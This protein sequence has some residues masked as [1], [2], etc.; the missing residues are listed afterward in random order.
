LGE[1]PWRFESSRPHLRSSSSSQGLLRVLR[2]GRVRGGRTR[3]PC[4]KPAL[5]LRRPG[6]E[7][8]SPSSA[9]SSPTGAAPVVSMRIRPA[10][11]DG[12][13]CLT[14]PR[15][16]TTRWPHRPGRGSMSSVAPGQSEAPSSFC[17]DAGRGLRRLPAPRAA[18][19][20][21]LVGHRLYVVGGVVAP[22]SLARQM[23]VLDLRTGRWSFV[24]GPQPGLHVS[25]ANEF[26]DLG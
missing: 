18:A 7:T 22:G 25:A 12:G 11:G 8:R 9:A 20:A 4:R 21:A 19:G 17:A 13:G 2:Y 1:S 10:P 24:P 23:L 26:L 5:R 15:R 16:S 3:N 14:C 6:L